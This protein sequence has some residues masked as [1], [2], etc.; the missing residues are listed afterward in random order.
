MKYRHAIRP[1]VVVALLASVFLA[2]CAAGSGTKKQ[3]ALAERAQ[4]RWDFLAAREPES[5]WQYLSR[6]AK[7]MTPKE[8]YIK[9]TLVKP[10]MWTG[11]RFLREECASELTCKVYMLVDYKIRS[12]LSGVGIIENSQVVVETW[13]NESETWYFLPSS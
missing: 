13:I 4:A 3:E 10:V 8:Q 7:D 9:E 11:A 12:H 1:Q 2:G 5:A 6:G